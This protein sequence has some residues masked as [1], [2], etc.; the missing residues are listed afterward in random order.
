M[1]SAV[2]LRETTL[3]DCDK[4]LY[5]RPETIMPAQWVTQLAIPSSSL[6]WPDHYFAQGRYT[7]KQSDN[8]P[9]RK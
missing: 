1:K 9:A 4:N 3:Q 7:H 6:V 2:L 5:W 8:A